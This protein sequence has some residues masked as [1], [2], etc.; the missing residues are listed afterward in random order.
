MP[1][2]SSPSIC[3]SS[4]RTSHSVSGPRERVQNTA[5]SMRSTSRSG[6]VPSKSSS[7]AASTLYRVSSI[8]LS[9]HASKSRTGSTGSVGVELRLPDPV[10]SI[11][12][13]PALSPGNRTAAEEVVEE[14]RVRFCWRGGSAG[15]G[16]VEEVPRLCWKDAPPERRLA[17]DACAGCPRTRLRGSSNDFAMLLYTSSVLTPPLFCARASRRTRAFM[18]SASLA[19][20]AR[21]RTTRPTS[22]DAMLIAR[23]SIVKVSVSRSSSTLTVARVCVMGTGEVCT[24]ASEKTAVNSSF[25]SVSSSDA[26]IP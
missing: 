25:T 23:S 7:A 15:C 12:A 8:S 2:G 19:F 22:V 9:L 24:G 5:S 4:T 6:S 13:S 3:A 16:S 21:T 14:L 26:W 11:P 17:S 1:S 20:K 10:W 18:A